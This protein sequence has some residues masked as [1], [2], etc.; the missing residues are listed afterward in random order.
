M[1]KQIQ[2][3]C[4]RLMCA[5]VLQLIVFII[6][7]PAVT[8][9]VFLGVYKHYRDMLF[10]IAISFNFSFAMLLCADGIKRNLPSEPFV[11]AIRYGEAEDVLRALKV[12]P[13]TKDAFYSIRP[14]G[15]TTVRLLAIFSDEKGTNL[16]AAK[17][18]A[19]AAINK[20]SE[21]KAEQPVYKAL[22]MLRLNVVIAQRADGMEMNS[23]LLCSQGRNEMI[24]EA[25]IFL[26]DRRL[27]IPC[28][29][30]G[31]DIHEIQRYRTAAMMLADALSS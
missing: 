30:K 11:L 17:K 28:V 15:K 7:P 31:A 5:A 2:V 4:R 25:V 6:L 20:L 16:K 24:L 18:R 3:Y 29:P 21:Y 26:Q 27:M 22:R 1:G 19:N 10:L 14:V 9:A 23:A 12:S 8:I 13:V